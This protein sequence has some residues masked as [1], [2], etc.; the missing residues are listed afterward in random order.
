M[1]HL[2][3]ILLFVVLASF[4]AEVVATATQAHWLEARENTE[5]EKRELQE[6]SIELGAFDKLAAAGGA[7]TADNFLL[8]SS[9]QGH[10]VEPTQIL[11]FGLE[12]LQY[13]LSLSILQKASPKHSIG[14][15]IPLFKKYKS[16]I[17][18]D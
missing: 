14:P 3:S 11:P 5:E 2:F 16:Y 17:F 18:Y 1:R 15:K 4:T 13:Y 7:P 8:L 10:W 6:L 12:L 9:I